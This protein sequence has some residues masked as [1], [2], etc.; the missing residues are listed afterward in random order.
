M[1]SHAFL[2]TRPRDCAPVKAPAAYATAGYYPTRYCVRYDASSATYRITLE[3]LV[4]RE[5]A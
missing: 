2:S 1:V 3:G 4:F 5:A